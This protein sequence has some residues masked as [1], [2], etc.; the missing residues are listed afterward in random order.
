MNKG[1]HNYSEEELPLHIESIGKKYRKTISRSNN[2]SGEKLSS[3]NSFRRL[4]K[5]ILVSEKSYIG[6]TKG[7]SFSNIS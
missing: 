7:N 2:S 1:K 4:K 6:K 3:V 5:T